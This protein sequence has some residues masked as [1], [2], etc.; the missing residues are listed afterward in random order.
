MWASFFCERKLCLIEI[1][2]EVC[3]QVFAGLKVL[4]FLKTAGFLLQSKMCFE[5]AKLF[6]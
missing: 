3:N 2:L 6:F 1:L 5:I 4:G